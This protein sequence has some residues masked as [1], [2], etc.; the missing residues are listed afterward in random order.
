MPVMR[1]L[2]NNVTEPCSGD[3]Q[4]STNQS[5]TNKTKWKA[6]AFLYIAG[7]DKKDVAEPFRVPHKF[8]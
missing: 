3:L 5:S 2:Y 6:K 1:N 8:E 7:K 4:V